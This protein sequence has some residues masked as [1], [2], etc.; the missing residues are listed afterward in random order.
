MRGGAASL[1]PPQ[2][3]SK[4]YQSTSFDFYNF[5]TLFLL[6]WPHEVWFPTVLQKIDFQKFFTIHIF[7]EVWC[8]TTKNTFS[9]FPKKFRG[10]MSEKPQNIEIL[11][12]TFWDTPPRLTNTPNNFRKFEFLF[13]GK[14]FIRELKVWKLVLENAFWH[15]KEAQFY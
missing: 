13:V 4:W 8:K 6:L 5:L 15:L 1:S 10:V 3:S 14:S 7:C 9:T 12:K 11:T 2:T